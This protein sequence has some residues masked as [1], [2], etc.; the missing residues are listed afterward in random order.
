MPLWKTRIVDQ[1]LETLPFPVAAFCMAG[2]FSSMPSDLT[3]SQGMHSVEC[4]LTML[5][6]S[7]IQND[8]KCLTKKFFL[9]L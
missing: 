4:L 7:E 5:V 2:F 1:M 8:T 3:C 9:Q 6:V